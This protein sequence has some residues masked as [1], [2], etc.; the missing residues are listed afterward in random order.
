MIVDQYIAKFD[1]LAKFSTNL[2][3]ASDEAWKSIMYEFGLR[4]GIKHSATHLEICNYVMLV[5]KCCIIE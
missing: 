2:R 5:N 4:L 3:N 1:E